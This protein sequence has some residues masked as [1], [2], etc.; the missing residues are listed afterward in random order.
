MNFILSGQ[1]TFYVL[2]FF[3][4]SNIK[5][6]YGNTRRNREHPKLPANV[7]SVYLVGFSAEL[8]RSDIKCVRT[9]YLTPKGGLARQVVVMELFDE[10]KQRWNTTGF[11]VTMNIP[12]WPIIFNLNIT[13]ITDLPPELQSL[14]ISMAY[15]ILHYDRNTM[16]LGDRVPGVYVRA[17][18]SLWV[19]HDYRDLSREL[20]FLT[21]HAFNWSCKS[22]K[23]QAYPKECLS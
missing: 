17:L 3:I 8:N 5:A 1:L 16:V 15:R 22:P 20:P 19:T 7:T 14:N 12:D 4:N 9:Y 11:H 23:Y 21:K 2:V 18:C 6:D 13:S 10:K